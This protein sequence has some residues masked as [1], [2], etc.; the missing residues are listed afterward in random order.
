MEREEISGISKE[1]DKVLEQVAAGTEVKKDKQVLTGAAAE[2][3]EGDRPVKAWRRPVKD[4]EAQ[5]IFDT[6]SEDGTSVWDK[7]EAGEISGEGEISGREEVS[8]QEKKS[9]RVN[10]CGRKQLSG[11]EEVS[12]HARRRSES[13]ERE[14]GRKSHTSAG[15]LHPSDGLLAAFFIPVII[16]VV[17]F[18]QRGIFPFGQESFLRTDMYHQYAPFFSEMQY[19]LTSGGSLLYSWDIGLGVNFAALYAYYLASPLNWLLI[20]C[21]KGL[22]IEF[23]TYSVVLKIGLCGL[24]FAY[25]LRKHNHTSDFGIGFF[26]VFYALS[27]Y[28]AAYSW[29]I[30]WLDCILL[31]PLIMLGMERLV[32]EKKGTLYCVTLGLSILSNYYIS[33]MICMFMV[34][35]FICLL[36]LE[37]RRSVKDCFVSLLQFAGYSLIAG[38]LA[39]VVLLPEIFALQ[40][41]AS[42]NINFP[43]KW[44]AYFSIFDM[45]ARHI[46]N[47][48]TEIGLDHWPNIFCGVAVYM[49]FLLFLICKKIPAKE[50]AVTSGLILMFFASFSINGLNFIWHGF[51]YPNSLPC[52]Q[53]FIYIFLMLSLCYRAYMYLEDTPKRHISFALFGAMGFV[54]LAQKLVTDE[55]AFHFSVF[56]V[57]LLFLALYAGLI[58][59]YKNSRHSKA[60]AALLTLAVVAIE[61]AANTA[62]TSVTTTS[63]S[64]YLADNKDVIT[65]TGD[66]ISENGFYRVDKVNAK[67]KNDGAWMNFPSVSLFSSLAHED[68]SAFFKKLGCESSTNAYSITG[69]TPLVDSLFSVKYALYP[70]EQ[71]VSNARQALNGTSGE[72]RLYENLHTLPLGFLMPA[73]MEESWQTDLPNPADVQNQLAVSIGAKPVLTEQAG[74]NMGISFSFTTKEAGEYYVYLLNKNVK[75]VSVTKEDISKN[76]D[77]VNRG[78]FIELGYCEA[79]VTV[80]VE[81]KDSSD[82]LNARVYRFEETG[83][84]QVYE[85]LNKNPLLLSS[86]EEDRF[87]GTITAEESGTMWLSIPYDKGWRVEID[88]APVTARKLFDAFLGLDLAAGSHTIT[89]RYIPEGLKEGALISV[90]AVLLLAATVIGGYALQKRSRKRKVT[91]YD[92]LDEEW[93]GMNREGDK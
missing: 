78:F 38:A 32:K 84:E 31:F 86:W 89:M 3:K 1:F 47:V 64:S 72:T 57:A 62:V 15:I 28:M 10:T 35:Y 56:Y 85:I 30:M 74:E 70:E 61:A 53:S 42:G 59:F 29:N 25:Y 39:A 82:E 83:L 21:P 46:G 79:G 80:T 76:Y 19:K 6:P 7:P 60:A 27:G 24:T 69:S 16:M 2:Q 40:S 90:L 8:G 67:T 44:E 93:H 66:L 23:M 51:H 22:I 5:E 13:G 68:L 26:G 88:G 58:Y 11:S 87:T 71:V 41:T 54:L 91:P 65:L 33:I 12:G 36:I 48:Q 17:I 75:S 73:A 4:G 45:L 52:R 50:K 37:G 92:K 43:R 77:N 34:L 63:R 18:A 49:F 9:R 20:L 55:E 14:S 81:N